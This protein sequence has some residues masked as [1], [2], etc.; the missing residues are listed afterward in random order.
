[1]SRGAGV[2]GL[3]AWAF[4]LWPGTHTRL[5]GMPPQGLGWGR[6]QTGQSCGERGFRG[7]RSGGRRRGT[8]PSS[9]H[10]G[11]NSQ[12]MKRVTSSSVP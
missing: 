1:V 10:P 4:T 6:L 9:R 8:Y 3:T 11:S 2:F 5:V 12:I 7:R